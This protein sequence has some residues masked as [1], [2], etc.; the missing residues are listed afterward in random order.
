[1]AELSPGFPEPSTSGTSTSGAAG[2]PGVPLRTK[3][4]PSLGDQLFQLP[5]D[6]NVIKHP[7]R[8][9]IS[10]KINF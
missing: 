1:M 3:A 5:E 6:V 7:F 4:D 2:F 9:C 10:G 8:M